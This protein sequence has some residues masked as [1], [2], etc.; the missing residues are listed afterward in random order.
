MKE[1]EQLKD[2]LHRATKEAEKLKKERKKSSSEVS[3]SSPVSTSE[4]T[5]EME[6][7]KR[8]QTLEDENQVCSL[9]YEG[10]C[11]CILHSIT[12]GISMFPKFFACC[13]PSLHPHSFNGMIFALVYTGAEG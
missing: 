5:F 8:C 11:S 10:H 6:Q 1:Q 7:R 2:R 4:M 12:K 3:I 9:A 13:I